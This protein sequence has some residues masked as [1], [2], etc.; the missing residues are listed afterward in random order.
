MS[1]RK[2]TVI[3]KGRTQATETVRYTDLWRFRR[4]WLQRSLDRIKIGGRNDNGRR[5][6]IKT[7]QEHAATETTVGSA[8]VPAFTRS[9]QE[10]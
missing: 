7:V 5:W 10:N 4:R 3:A 9:P 2:A 1:I 6:V 8:G